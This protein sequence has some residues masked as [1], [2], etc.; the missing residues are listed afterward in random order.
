MAQKFP[1]FYLYF[2]W[3]DALSSIPPAKAMCII[4]N[5]RRY[6]EDGT[7]P[8]PLTGAA[9]CIQLMMLA[10]LMRAKASAEY[11]RLGGAPAHKKRSEYLAFLDRKV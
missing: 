4:Q 9:N 11:G 5:M 1:G 7:N 3:I 8:P 10:Q 6:L 2:D